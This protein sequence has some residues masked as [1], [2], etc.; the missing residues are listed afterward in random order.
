[1]KI[2]LSW[3]D[4]AKPIDCISKPLHL[5]LNQ[6]LKHLIMKL[7]N[8]TD[9]VPKKGPAESFM[10]IGVR[11]PLSKTK[12]RTFIKGR[13]RCDVRREG[14]AATAVCGARGLALQ[15]GASQKQRKS[16]EP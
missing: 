2:Y 12:T 3:G 13:S 14:G 6:V 5:F 8:W 1:L 15:Q 11:N 4:K 7:E 16:T 9:W 10:D